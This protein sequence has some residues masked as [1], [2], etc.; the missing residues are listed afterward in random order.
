MLVASTAS[1]YKFVRNVMTAI[2]PKYDEMEDFALLMSL[3]KY[4]A[5]RFQM[6]SKKSV[7]QRFVIQ[8]SVMQIR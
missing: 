1:P 2:D 3:K 7:M 5:S 4:L 8:Q 6:R